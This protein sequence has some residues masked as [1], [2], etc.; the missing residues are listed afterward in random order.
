MWDQY[1]RGEESAE[2]GSCLVQA[3]R[4]DITVEVLFVARKCPAFPVYL[5][6]QA[7]EEIKSSLPIYRPVDWP[8]IIS[9]GRGNTPKGMSMPGTSVPRY[10]G[11]HLQSSIPLHQTPAGFLRI[12]ISVAA[13]QPRAA[14]GSVFPRPV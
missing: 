14:A 2:N 7:G 11:L 8:A 10:I 6:I 12:I 13:W 1:R 9:K 4:N 3:C 5:R